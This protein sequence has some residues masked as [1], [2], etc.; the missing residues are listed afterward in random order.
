MTPEQAADR[1]R[2]YS[3]RKD[4]HEPR[5]LESRDFSARV[6]FTSLLEGRRGLW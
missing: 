2:D 4:P 3:G 1:K 5:P 6:H